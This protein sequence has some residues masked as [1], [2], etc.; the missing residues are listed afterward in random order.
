M[1]HHPPDFRRHVRPFFLTP[2]GQRSTPYKIYYDIFTYFVTQTAFCFTTAPFV[3]LT[4]PSSLLVWARVY[5]YTIVGTA[6][7]MAFFASPAK[8]WLEQKL[9]TRNQH[10]LQPQKENAEHR[11]GVLGLPDDP[12]G[13]IDEAVQEIRE[14]VEAR[15]RRGQSINMPTGADLRAA[16]EA[17]LGKKL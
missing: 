11:M 5:F 16:V 7:S 2:D 3:L 10:A 12:A 13:D 8:P 14:E 6:A 9:K 1:T 17:K 15:R 4:L